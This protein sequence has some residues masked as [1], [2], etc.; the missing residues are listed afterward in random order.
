MVRFFT[1]TAAEEVTVDPADLR[2][3]C[4]PRTSDGVHLG[5]ALMHL[6]R[7][8]MPHAGAGALRAWMS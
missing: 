8:E 6:P 3:R 4:V 1:P 5:L 2:R 7:A